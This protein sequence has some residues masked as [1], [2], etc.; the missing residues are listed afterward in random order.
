MLIY[1][2]SFK[3]K[4]YIAIRKIKTTYGKIKYRKLKY[5]TELVKAKEDLQARHFKYGLDYKHVSA[6][7]FFIH[8]NQPKEFSSM[9]YNL[10]PYGPFFIE[11]LKLSKF[12]NTPEI[13]AYFEKLFDNESFIYSLPDIVKTRN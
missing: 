4:H 5:Q 2:E 9:S 1:D 6:L 12:T 3:E 8:K 7:L 11:T 10:R 13:I